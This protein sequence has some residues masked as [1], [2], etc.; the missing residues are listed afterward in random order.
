MG[1]GWPGIRVCPMNVAQVD[2]F[3]LMSY[4]ARTRPLIERIPNSINL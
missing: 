1:V 4:W 2:F 3:I